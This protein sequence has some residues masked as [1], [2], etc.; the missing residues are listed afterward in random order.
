MSVIAGILGVVW[1]GF[2]AQP[3]WFNN[4]PFEYVETHQSLKECQIAGEGTSDICVGEGMR[5]TKSFE[6]PK[7]TKKVAELE[8]VECDYWAGCYFSN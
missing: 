6:A 8:Y 5:Y 4:G 2:V 1:G 3:E 7:Q